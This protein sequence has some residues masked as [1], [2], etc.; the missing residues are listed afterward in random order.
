[1]TNRIENITSQLAVGDSVRRGEV[2]GNMRPHMGRFVLQLEVRVAG[3]RTDPAPFFDLSGMMNDL[4]FLTRPMVN[5]YAGF[6][7]VSDFTIR[8]TSLGCFCYLP[9]PFSSTCF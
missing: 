7:T 4:D 9:P 8:S 5:F 1:M 6:V 2:I 3:E